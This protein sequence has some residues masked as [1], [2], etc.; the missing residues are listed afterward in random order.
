MHEILEVDGLRVDIEEVCVVKQASFRV[1]QGESVALLGP[2]GAGKTTLI[3]AL[4][5]TRRSASGKIVLDGRDITRSSP[6][7]RVRAGLV[8]VPQGRMLFSDLTVMENLKIGAGVKRPGETRS[9]NWDAMY[10]MF[11]KLRELAPRKAGAL[12]GGEQQMVAVGRAMLARPRLLVLDEPSLG[13]APNMVDNLYA[14]LQRIRNVGTAVLVV[15]QLVG[16]ALRLTDHAHVLR[17]GMLTYAG[18]SPNLL[19]SSQFIEHYFVT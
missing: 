6:E 18:R 8:L 9:A 15:E 11:P 4:S 10:D 3:S 13:L 1:M 5:G 14:A 19:T 17:Q 16:R 12:S 2:N 7:E